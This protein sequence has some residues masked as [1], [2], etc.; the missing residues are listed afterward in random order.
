MNLVYITDYLF[1]HAKNIPEKTFINFEDKNYSFSKVADLVLKAST[2]INEKIQNNSDQKIIAILLPNSPEFIYAYLGVVHAGHIAMP[3]DPNFKKLEAQNVIDQMQP[4]LIITDSDHLNYFDNQNVVI[5]D[6][7]LQDAGTR[8]TRF[9]RQDPDKQVVSMLFTSGT[10]GRPKATPYSHANHLWNINAVSKLWSWTDKDTLLISLPLSHWHGLCVGLTG[11]LV[12]GNTLYLQER[13]D[14]AL[15]IQALESGDISLFMHVPIAYQKL[16]EHDPDTQFDLSKVR[17]CISGSSFLPPALWQKFKT[18]FSQ[19]ILERYG[20]SEMG[21]LSSNTLD[22]RVPGS[23]GK[24]LDGVQIKIQEDGE[25]AMRSPGL[26]LGYWQNDSATKEHSTSDGYWLSGDI[27]ELDVNNNLY[28]KGRVQEKMKKFGYTVYPRDVEWALMK[29]PGVRE[30]SVM[31]IQNQDQLSDEFI[32]FVVGNV[33]EAEI[34]E[35]SKT[36]MPN[37]WRPD[38]VIFIEAIP[39]MGR[40]NKPNLKKLRE[41]ATA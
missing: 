13:F 30:A 6:T 7:L 35:F 8:Y 4:D 12:H 17:L 37:F 20:A 22:S 21:F 39:R 40:A 15:T 23:V 33:S 41:I 11:G 25:I 18:R 14:P 10:T 29:I 32:Y 16:V 27:G 24:I 36:G 34:L 3:L 19:E 31:S 2:N 1:E 5:I 26:F 38:R 9:L 28:L